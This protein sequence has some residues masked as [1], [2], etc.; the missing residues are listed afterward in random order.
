M[1]VKDLGK[2]RAA[3]GSQEWLTK[4]YAGETHTPM[5]SK[6]G[7]VKVNAFVAN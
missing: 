1:S 5:G 2:T 6:D 4:A 7:V 3:L